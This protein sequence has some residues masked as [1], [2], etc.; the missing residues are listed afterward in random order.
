MAR[1]LPARLNNSILQRLEQPALAWMASRLPARVT[2]DLLTGIG[3]FGSLVAA[4]AY[5]AAASHPAYLWLASFGLAMNWFGDSLDGSIA[6]MRKI[7][8]PRYGFFLDQNIEFGSLNLRILISWFDVDHRLAIRLHPC[9]LV[10]S[11]TKSIREVFQAPRWHG[12][13][14]QQNVARQ[15][16]VFTSKRV[17]DP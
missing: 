12:A 6:R 9:G 11:G 17:V 7:E 8:R 1:E 16:L 10:C 5:M 4:G 15:I 14:M 2:P 3:L 13:S